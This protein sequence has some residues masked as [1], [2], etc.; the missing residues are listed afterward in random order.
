MNKEDLALNNLQGLI[1]CKIQPTNQPTYIDWYLFISGFESEI[2]VML[3]I[4]LYMS[5]GWLKSFPIT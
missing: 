1:Y 2:L 3:V 4:W 5:I